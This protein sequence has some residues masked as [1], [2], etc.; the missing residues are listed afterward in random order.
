MIKYL[1]KRI[2]DHCN[3]TMSLDLIY[4]TVRKV[5]AGTVATYGQIAKIC[6]FP[7]HARH[8]GHALRKLGENESQRVPWHRI[9]NANGGI[10]DRSTHGDCE[11]FQRILLEQEGV[12]FDKNGRIPM[13]RFQ[14]QS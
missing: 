14:W 4:K 1:V 6:G 12:E 11:S 7:N 2:D 8:V 5:P 9:V 10:S 13:K 3:M